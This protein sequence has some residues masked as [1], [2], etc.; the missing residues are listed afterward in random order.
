MSLSPFTNGKNRSQSRTFWQAVASA[1]VVA[2]LPSIFDLDRAFVCVC[3]CV[4]HK[5][6][7]KSRSDRERKKERKKERKREKERIDTG[8]SRRA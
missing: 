2:S 4:K 3:V 8:H 1:T 7:H 6:P 5:H